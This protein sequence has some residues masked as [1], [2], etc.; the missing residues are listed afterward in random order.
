[1]LGSLVSVGHSDS[2]ENRDNLQPASRGEA[3]AHVHFSVDGLEGIVRE[4]WD[5]FVE[6]PL[7]P[8]LSTLSGGKG[9]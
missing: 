8:Y 6:M 9:C 3:F 5:D 2:G 1:M 7:K 4:M